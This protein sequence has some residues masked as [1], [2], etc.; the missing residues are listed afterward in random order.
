MFPSLYENKQHKPN[1][2]TEKYKVI[3]ALYYPVAW[4]YGLSDVGRILH[5]ALRGFNICAVKIG[6]SKELSLFMGVI[7]NVLM[8]APMF[9]LSEK[10]HGKGISI[11]KEF[12]DRRGLGQSFQWMG[13]C[14]ELQGN[15]EKALHYFN[16]RPWITL[17]KSETLKSRA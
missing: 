1:T 3:A 12:H 5:V 6:K 8:A 10:Y 13:Y 7:G 9:P 11:K 4:A 15:Y 17:K 16:T 2:N 14:Y